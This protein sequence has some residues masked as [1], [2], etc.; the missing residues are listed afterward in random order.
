M[1]T[2]AVCVALTVPKEITK[3]VFKHLDAPD[4]VNAS[5]TC[6]QWSNYTQEMREGWKEEYAERN[7][8]SLFSP[9]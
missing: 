6:R 8:E 3:H 4:L 1:S 9:D 7:E 2:E 5:E